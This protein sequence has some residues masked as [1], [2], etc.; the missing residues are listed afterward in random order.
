MPVYCDHAI[1]RPEDFYKS[2]GVSR[3]HKKDSFNAGSVNEGD[4]VFVKTDYIYNGYFQNYILPNI[5]NKFYLVSGISSYHV[6]SNG[7]ESYL[8]I[9]NNQKVLRWFCTNPPN[10]LSK[11]IVPLPIGFEESE[12]PGGNQNLIAQ[13]H[14]HKSPFRDKK[15]KI[16][17][18]HHTL[19]TN[20]SRAKLFDELSNLDFVEVQDEKLSWQDYMG[21]IDSYKYVICLEGSGPDVHRN[22]ECLLMGSVPINI[23]NTIESLF[24]YHKLPGIFLKKWGSLNIEN[25]RSKQ[26]DFTNVDKFLKIQYHL[27]LMREAL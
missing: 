23:R 13:L 21:K 11:K 17:L 5:K 1:D 24:E 6:G 20:P 4:F 8:N 19:N 12:R 9:L 2:V 26:Y 16:L 10:F 7:D 27:D 18:P 14:K 22:Y 3:L 15:D 25:I